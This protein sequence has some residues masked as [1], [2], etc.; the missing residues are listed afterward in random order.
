[1][2]IYKN[3]I[4][5][6]ESKVMTDE[7]DGGGEMTGVEIISG[8]HNSIFNDISTLQRTYGS[9]GIRSV[10]AKVDSPTNETYFGATIGLS[11]TPQDPNVDI[12]LVSVNNPYIERNETKE[13][14]ERYLTSGVK[15]QGELF[16]DQVAGQRAIR[17]MQ[18]THRKAPS[19]GEVLIVRNKQTGFEQYCKVV[20]SSYEDQYFY[21]VNEGGFTLRIVTCEISEPLRQTVP[22]QSPNRAVVASNVAEI[23]ETMIADASKYYGTKSLKINA[24]FNESVLRVESIYNQLVPS[25]RVDEAHVN[26]P[27]VELVNAP[28]AIN[29]SGTEET[30]LPVN[31]E[32]QSFPIDIDNQGYVYVQTLLPYPTKGTLMVHYISQGNWYTL[33]DDGTGV[34]KGADPSHGTGSLDALGNVSVTTGALPDVTSE[35]IFQWASSSIQTE[36]IT[37]A[38]LLLTKTFVHEL[39]SVPNNNDM[40]FTWDDKTAHCIGGEITGDATGYVNNKKIEFTPNSLPAV[41]SVVN[42]AWSENAGGVVPSHHEVSTIPITDTGTHYTF[43]R[44]INKRATATLQLKAIDYS[45]TNGRATTT[46]E[47]YPI[48][49]IFNEN[50]TVTH[51][52]VMPSYDNEGNATQDGIQETHVIGVYNKATG[53][54][55]LEI[56]LLSVVVVTQE[57]EKKRSHWWKSKNWTVTERVRRILP[58]I[59]PTGTVE[60]STWVNIQATP[61]IAS[62]SSHFTLDAVDVSFDE[63][64][65]DVLDE[66]VS[67][68]LNGKTYDLS[69]NF[70]TTTNT[71]TITDWNTGDDI[72]TIITG[73]YQY[74]VKQFVQDMVFLTAGN[75]VAARSLQINAVDINGKHCTGVAD[76]NGNIS[77][78]GFQGTIDLELGIVLLNNDNPVESVDIKYNCVS[79]NYLPLDAELLGLDPIRLPSDGRVVIYEKG[80][81]V[82]VHQD[83]QLTVT[84]EANE[85]VQLDEVR[86]TSCTTTAKDALIDLDAGTILYPTAG[87]FDITYRF[88]D[89]ALLTYVDI[90]GALKTSRPLSHSYDANKAKVA[91]LLIAGDL[92]SR[93]TN[94][95]DQKTW[96]NVFSENRIG[97]KAIAEYNDTLYPI[98]VTNDGCITERFAIVFTSSTNF[99]L[100]GEHVGQIAVGDVNTDFAPINPVSGTPY[101]T[102]KKLGW[103]TGWATNNVLRIDFYGAVYQMNIIRTI[104]QGESENPLQSD[105]F[106]LQIRG[107]INKEVA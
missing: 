82:V 30:T 29:A 5:L 71:L 31:L 80:D 48:T 21:N 66:T 78:D 33:T 23:S 43:N 72:P 64:G 47:T 54:V 73:L 14:I 32:S 68:S 87:T 62:G 83:E 10:H 49:L 34:L 6:F 24:L 45:V 89:I 41:G 59:N 94:L 98:Q 8:E 60:L 42:V 55:T 50:E 51:V 7:S 92:F 1:M 53:D 15:Y 69:T 65:V 38:D 76:A 27:I 63:N 105:K 95:F 3:D 39:G 13:L 26:V 91:S 9:V 90:S 19:A 102:L 40:T 36:L 77:G 57:W 99:K 4:K 58:A 17:I 101:F 107:N 84:V 104:L 103:G 37:N 100:I 28:I 20:K 12:T 52:T 18:Y 35:M 75:P 22:G 16:Y 46:Q 74:S 44:G 56:A 67:F 96:T 97:D 93:Y 86:L 70:N 61:P 11:E 106:A 25:A 79:Y 88:E 85:V 81:V 2:T